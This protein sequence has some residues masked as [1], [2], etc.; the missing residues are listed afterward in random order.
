MHNGVVSA[1]CGCR[2]RRIATNNMKNHLANRVRSEN[3]SSCGIKNRARNPFRP[4][5]FFTKA[6]LLFQL[7]AELQ[8]QARRGFDHPRQPKIQV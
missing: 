1:S 2:Y 7:I 8:Q 4:F 5:N 3:F 6:D